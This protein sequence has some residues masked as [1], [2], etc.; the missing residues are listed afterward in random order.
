MSGTE[1]LENDF[2]SNATAAAQF[3]SV[4][5]RDGSP[6]FPKARSLEMP[7]YPGAHGVVHHHEFESV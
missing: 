5:A 4:P 2:R 6:H 3:Q 7:L 1:L